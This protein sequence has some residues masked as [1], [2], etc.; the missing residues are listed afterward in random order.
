MSVN[1]SLVLRPPQARMQRSSNPSHSSSASQS[2]QSGSLL[3]PAPETMPA[4]EFVDDEMRGRPSCSDNED[5]HG[6]VFIT[7]LLTRVTDFEHLTFR[8]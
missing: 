3:P 6:D 2:H 8:Q 4:M 5:S 7:S 1:G